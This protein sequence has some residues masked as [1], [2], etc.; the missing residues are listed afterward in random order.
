MA[1]VKGYI[2]ASVGDGALSLLAV[3]DIP[4]PE[5]ANLAFADALREVATEVAE[6]GEDHVPTSELEAMLTGDPE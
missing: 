1:A 4:T 6:G 3:V 5:A 2:W